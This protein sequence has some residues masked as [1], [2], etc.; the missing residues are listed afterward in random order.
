MAQDSECISPFHRVQAC[1]RDPALHTFQ[2][3]NIM[4]FLLEYVDDL[5]TAGNNFEILNCFVFKINSKLKACTIEYLDRLLGIVIEQGD[6]WVNLHQKGFTN[7][8]LQMF[9]VTDCNPSHTPMLTETGFAPDELPLLGNWRRYQQL[10]K[11]LLYHSNST[12]PDIAYATGYVV[13]T[14]S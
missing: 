5:I 2:E 6:G 3:G 9:Q 8:I 12:R 10:V 1:I 11:S 4:N 13:Q 7:Q 14:N